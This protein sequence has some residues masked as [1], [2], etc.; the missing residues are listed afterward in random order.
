MIY[1]KFGKLPGI[2]E[3]NIQQTKKYNVEAA[4]IS[5]VFSYD[6][7]E[8]KINITRNPKVNGRWYIMG[9]P[10]IDADSHLY[11]YPNKSGEH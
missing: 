8:N 6:G 10:K 3:P 4:D 7:E 9:L 1:R 11:D 5:I 2:K